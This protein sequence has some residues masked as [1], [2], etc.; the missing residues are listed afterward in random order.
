MKTEINKWDY[1]KLRS[2]CNSKDTVTKVQRQSTEWERI[3][4]QYPTNKGLISR[5]Y[6]ALVE[7]HKK[8]TANLIKKWGDE[9]NRNF[10][11]EEI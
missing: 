6:K 1:L 5:I 7:L 2:F 11:K 9:M 8:K 4:T 3:F 10:P